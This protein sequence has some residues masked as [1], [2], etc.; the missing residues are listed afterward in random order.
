M[1]DEIMI[2]DVVKIQS[3]Y[4]DAGKIALVIGI[5]KSEWIAKKSGW[6][7]FDYVIFNEKGQVFS[8][9]S[10]CIEKIINSS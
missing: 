2:G 9:S 6:V 10:N 3:N 4:Q 1:V 8:V 7:S 5:N